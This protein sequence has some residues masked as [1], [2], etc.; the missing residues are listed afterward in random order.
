MTAIHVDPNNAY[1]SS[2]DGVL[3]DKG[4]EKLIISP[5]GRTLADYVIPSTVHTIGLF[6]FAD[7]TAL[8]RV[9]IPASVT[10][11]EYCAFS[12]CSGLT[13]V[14]IPSSVTTVSMNVFGAC[15]SAQIHCQAAEKSSGWH[16]DWDSYTGTD[17][18]TWGCSE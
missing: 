10:T 1:F 9:T 15:W 6:G 18:V 11:I 3:F 8:T 5:C 7:N 4:M 13:S 16:D 17:A 12:N 14:F 2:L